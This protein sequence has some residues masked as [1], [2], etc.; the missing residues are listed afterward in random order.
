MSEQRSPA[1]DSSN[2]P[3]DFR[4][5]SGDA[6]VRL[7]ANVSVKYN[8]GGPV[9]GIHIEHVD[10]T[11]I[12]GTSMAEV[13][14]L[15]EKIRTEYEPRPYTGECP[16]IG[17][18]PF[19]EDDAGRFYGREALV[20]KLVGRV[21]T[22]RFLAVTGTSGSGKS[23]L[24]RA[25]LVP[26][27]KKRRNWHTVI[28]R[29]GRDPLLALGTAAASLLGSLEPQDDLQKEGVRHPARFLRWLNLALG[30][31]PNRQAL[32]VIDQFEEIFSPTGPNGE[33]VRAAF[34]QA[35][36][37]AAQDPDRRIHV[38]VTLRSDFIPR[39]ASYPGM[40]DLLN[41]GFYQVSPLTPEELARAIAIPA[42]HAGLRIDPHLIQQIIS[43]MGSE[44]GALPL[45]QFTLE[46]LFDY[47]KTRHGVAA[48][49]LDGYLALGG[50]NRSLETYADGAF[51]T[52]NPHEQAL[53]R[54]VFAALIV[55]GKKRQEDTGRTV[56][57]EQL[58][59]ENASLLEVEALVNRL[60]DA[61]LLITQERTARLPHEKMLEAWPW[62]AKLADDNRATALQAR[63]INEDA[64]RWD[65]AG[66]EASY[67]YRGAQLLTAEEKIASGQLK[68]G[69]QAVEFLS[70]ARSQEDIQKFAEVI[71]LRERLETD[72]KLRRYTSLIGGVLAA[73][74]AIFFLVYL[75]I[76]SVG[77]RL[78][79]PASGGG[80]VA[81]G[82]AGTVEKSRFIMQ[83]W[84][85]P[86]QVSAGFLVGLD[87]LYMLIY[88]VLFY[89]LTNWTAGRVGH[90]S[91]LAGKIG[92]W[93]ARIQL[94]NIL[95]DGAENVALA[96]QLL[97][98]LEP[99]WPQIALW[100]GMVKGGIVM[101][102]L[103]Y[104]VVALI[105]IPI[106][107]GVKIF[108]I[109]SEITDPIRKVM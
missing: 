81:W 60:A 8:Q 40:N 82:F 100:A 65:Q 58:V 75:S 33:L 47:E 7:T 3:D 76:S 71:R 92:G 91:P 29:P 4:D 10:G 17:L 23:S 68:P 87:F 46:R 13:E 31:G 25:G 103:T 79:S 94:L 93:V 107:S 62:L 99:P 28:L 78:V 1:N 27:I 63:E 39:F 74:T 57:F 16:Y 54:S 64:E 35:L 45:L 95:F 37:Q 85:F 6:S 36:E 32:V 41:E 30:D 67:L 77:A 52:L 59:P 88:P 55:P 86:A 21:Q 66:R 72:R 97:I 2:S 50:L 96:Y 56:D 22:G 84:D 90:F 38:A 108:S 18:E 104:L 19:Q 89:A 53:T 106:R 61:R 42:I 15:L 105:L 98:A 14:A 34:L 83:Q 102:A 20:Q 80:I 12:T 24:V 26:D 73:V 109:K 101:L 70:A 69:K 43:E 11:V 48:L 5:T 49:T 51:A 9:T 44:P